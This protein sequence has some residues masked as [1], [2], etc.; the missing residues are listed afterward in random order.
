MSRVLVPIGLLVFVCT[1]AMGATSMARQRAHELRWIHRDLGRL[2]QMWQE[3]SL[4]NPGNRHAQ[5]RAYLALIRVEWD[6]QSSEQQAQY[7][8]HAQAE[9]ADRARLEE[10]TA[11]SAGRARLANALARGAGCGGCRGDALSGLGQ[12][13]TAPPSCSKPGRVDGEAMPVASSE[14]CFPTCPAAS[15]TTLWLHR[16]GPSCSTAL[17]PQIACSGPAVPPPSWSTVRVG[18]VDP[19]STPAALGSSSSPPPP[20]VGAAPSSVLPTAGLQ[21]SGARR[22]GGR[23]PNRRIARCCRRPT[24]GCMSRSSSQRPAQ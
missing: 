15:L 1:S 4:A 20:L 18:A 8:N 10:A 2:P 12:S 24:R 23:L 19:T 22:V 5:S 3:A 7:I 13:A 17:L 11:Q 16:I 14:S 21:G 9:E 6:S